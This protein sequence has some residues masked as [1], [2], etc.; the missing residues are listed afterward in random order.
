MGGYHHEPLLGFLEGKLQD[1]IRKAVSMPGFWTWG[2]G[3]RIT[4]NNPPEVIKI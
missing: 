4:K 2:W 1:V 3:G